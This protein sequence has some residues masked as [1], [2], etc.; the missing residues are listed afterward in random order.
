MATVSSEQEHVAP[1]EE[2]VVFSRKAGVVASRVSYV[3]LLDSAN[4]WQVLESPVR[5]FCWYSFASETEPAS[6]RPCR[7]CCFLFVGV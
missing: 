6:C 3:D 1:G 2:Q 7:R 4:A 5:L